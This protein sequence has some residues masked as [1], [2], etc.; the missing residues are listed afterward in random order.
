MSVWTVS[1][2]W[3]DPDAIRR[4]GRGIRLDPTE[5]TVGGAANPDLIELVAEPYVSVD[6]VIEQLGELEARLVERD[7]RRSIF[8]TVYTE[9]TEHTASAIDAGQFDDPGWMRRYLVRFAEYYR[10]AFRGFETGTYTQV[11]DPWIVAFGTAIRGDA[12]VIQDAFLGINAHIVHDLALTLSDVGLDPDRESKYADHRRVDDILARLVIIQRELLAEQYAPGLSRIGK[13]IAGLDE[14]W[15]AST[16]RG[17]RETAWRA[18]V[19]RTDTRWRRIKTA[20]DWLLSRTATG[21]ASF[22]LSPTVSP[23]TMEA[24]HAVEADRVDIGSYAR[25]FHERA[26]VEK[27]IEG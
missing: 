25:G 16:L 10:R 7:D 4:L 12:L 26:T 3:F 24:L 19:V 22:L 23:S 27:V 11:P 13:S 14:R 20:T 5:F 9:M 1:P 15:S 17:A 18:A 21:G 2:W 6:D 8:L